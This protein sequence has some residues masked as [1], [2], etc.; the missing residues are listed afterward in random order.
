MATMS[1]SGPVPAIQGQLTASAILSERENE[2]RENFI[3]YFMECLDVEYRFLEDVAAGRHEARIAERDQYMNM[4]LSAISMVSG[5]ASNTIGIG[6]AGFIIDAFVS[7]AKK[8][9]QNNANDKS[10]SQLAGMVPVLTRVQRETVFSLIGAE[11]WCRYGPAVINFVCRPTVNGNIDV[12]LKGICRIGAIRVLFYAMNNGIRLTGNN[13]PAMVDGIMAAF[14]SFPEKTKLQQFFKGELTFGT[15]KLSVQGLYTEAG[16]LEP[17]LSCWVRGDIVVPVARAQQG[18]SGSTHP[19]M[20]PYGM[21]CVP[22]QYLRP[23]MYVRHNYQRADSEVLGVKLSLEFKHR[24]VCFEQILEYL[25]AVKG[26]T[27][28][29]PFGAWLCASPTYSQEFQAVNVEEFVPAYRGRLDGSVLAMS[30]VDFG[31]G[32]FDGCDFS[33]CTLTRL[34]IKSMK[35]VNLYGSEI[36][37]STIVAAAM[38]GSLFCMCRIVQCSFQGTR[39]MLSF[40]YCSFARSTFAQARLQM[41]WDGK[42]DTHRQM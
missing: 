33:Y 5:T 9:I 10:S 41:S 17:G 16:L 7:L 29:Q 19:D 6:G 28:P 18:K 11:M 32:I 38:N 8:R 4:L 24:F 23:Q 14:D 31:D 36:S 22:P 3:A 35:Q 39:G 13:V 30:G 2:C 40:K 1:A 12:M 15:T 37:E 25:R 21:M 27:S 42:Y 20:F 26:V 34:M